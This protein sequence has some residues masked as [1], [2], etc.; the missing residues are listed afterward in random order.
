MAR[1]DGRPVTVADVAQLAGVHKATV[2]R[3][4]N[5]RTQTM[6][7]ADTVRRVKRAARD[8]GYVPNIVARGL[9]TNAS[10]TIGVVI[11]DL[12]NP[13][14]PPVVRGIESYLQ[15]RGYTALLA[16]TDWDNETE[17][18]LFASLLGRRVDG[19]IIATGRQDDQP[20]LE[21]VHAAGVRAVL[22]NRDA[23]SLR[24]PLVTGDDAR[25]IEAAVAHLV[26]LGHT[27]IAHL[28]GPPG[29]STSTVRAEAF[30]AAMRE[31][32]GVDGTV[33]D[34]SAL[35]V[36][37]GERAAPALLDDPHVTAIIA[38]NDLIAVGV[39]RALRA[40]GLECPTDV[41]VVGFNDMPF[42]QDLH[43]AL[44]TVHVP[45]TDMG[46][47]AARLLVDAIHGAAQEPVRVL[48][49]VSLTVRGSTGPAPGR[50]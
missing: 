6:I 39:L 29:F 30:R 27:R 48:L 4:L 22:V 31:Y 11:P 46:M 28:A 41:S 49:P 23:G 10:M 44:T 25:G 7:S 32:P 50:G 26:A 8:L 1:A 17:E 42:A 21:H 37:A 16:N 45:K 14:F 19:L 18:A 15:P 34:T 9:R 33:I 35:S 24:Y 12:T 3:A 5:P 38:G 2:S 13:F 40:R 47:Q 43:P 36:A 20:V